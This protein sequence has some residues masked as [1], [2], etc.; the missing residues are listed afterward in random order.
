MA[1]GFDGMGITH[2]APEPST[3]KLKG[4]CDGN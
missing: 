1:G 3:T 2:G 4:W